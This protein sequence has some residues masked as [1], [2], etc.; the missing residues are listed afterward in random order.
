MHPM[1]IVSGGQTGADR[2]ALDVAI[3]LA[4]PHR[5]WVPRGR[6]AED[7]VLAP[8][9]R[10]AETPMAN[11]AQR[12]E[13]NVRDSEA[14]LIV[15]HGALSGGSALT[16]RLAHRYGRPCLHLDFSAESPAVAFTSLTRWLVSGGFAT[17]NVAGPRASEDPAIH[18]AA[19]VLLRRVLSSS[20]PPAGAGG[21]HD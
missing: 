10:L 11:P 7:G 20:S 18:A 4:I 15:S 2:A 16:E 3:E 13:W 19:H 6:L 1:V 9:Y 8:R 14:T 12:T 5:G 21:V 17:L